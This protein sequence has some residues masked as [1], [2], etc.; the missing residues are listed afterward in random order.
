MTLALHSEI[1]REPV[2]LHP[3]IDGETEKQDLPKGH[4]AWISGQRLWKNPDAEIA[5]I[6]LSCPSLK[7]P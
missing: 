4:T 3:F 2:S 6:S 7:G 5:K 1:Q